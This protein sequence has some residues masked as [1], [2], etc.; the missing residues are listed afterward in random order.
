MLYDNI[1][2]TQLEI[3]TT[4][5]A[6]AYLTV[7]KAL[8]KTKLAIIKAI[9]FVLNWLY[10]Q[11]RKIALGIIIFLASNGVLYKIIVEVV[12]FLIVYVIRIINLET[13]IVVFQMLRAL[14]TFVY[15]KLKYIPSFIWIPVMIILVFVSAV[16][17]ANYR[18]KKNHERLKSFA[19]DELTQTTFIN[20]PPGTGKT[21]LNVS[22]SLTSVGILHLI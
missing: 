16:S 13:Y 14:F 9:K 17:R 5:F 2:G 11:R 4:P 3:K 12:I 15:P 8:N 22:L 6:G 21:L 19:K 20:G 1:N 10:K 7:S 18:L